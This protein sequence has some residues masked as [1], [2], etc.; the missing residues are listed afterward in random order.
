VSLKSNVRAVL[1][2]L[3]GVLLDTEP[4]YTKGIQQVVSAW[5]KVY[6]WSIKRD[7]IGR[8][9]LEG[10]R[11][12]I[13]RLELPVSIE[14]YMALREPALLALFANAPHMQGAPE[15]VQALA[16]R[17]V[18]MAVA[19]SSKASLFQLK[20]TPHGFFSA[21]QSIVCGDDPEVKALKP[22]PDIFLT[23]ARR[24][25]QVPAECLVIEDSPAGVRA[26]KSAGM[27]V[28]AIP[29]PGL[30][31]DAVAAADLVVHDYVELTRAVLAALAR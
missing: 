11:V 22:A 26:A 8:S 1:F 2:D 13:S 12:L 23:A 3:D 29:D 4:L 28:I 19:T 21:F 17:S 14:E 27:Q 18:P 7:M 30:G 20:S 25:A 5:G 16:E 6:D 24:I 9:E 31:D 15:L 10:A